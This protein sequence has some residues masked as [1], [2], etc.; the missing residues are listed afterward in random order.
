MAAVA[1]QEAASGNTDGVRLL[2]TLS[3][4]LLQRFGGCGGAA[5]EA[6]LRLQGGA[7]P[8]AG[9][10]VEEGEAEDGD[11]EEDLEA[12]AL[13]VELLPELGALWGPS[14]REQADLGTWRQG[15]AMSDE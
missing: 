9:G 2:A 4:E 13:L 6:R 15:R 10:A 5:G 3:L 11:E 8:G 12:V 1:R 14:G 7:W